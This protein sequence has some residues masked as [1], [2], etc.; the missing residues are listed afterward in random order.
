MKKKKIIILLT[1]MAIGAIILVLL[2]KGK[3]PSPGPSSPTT[4]QDTKMSFLQALPPEGKQPLVFTSSAILFKFSKPINLY[5]ANV[6]IE[7]TVAIEVSTANSD[8]A[9]LKVQPK[10]PWK[11]GVV[12]TIIIN[13]GLASSD[14]KQLEKDVVYKIEFEYPENITIY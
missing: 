14:S 10:K 2:K 6:Q 8:P 12:Y 4:S 9:T 5:T 7:P 11:E 13:K 1:V 3:T